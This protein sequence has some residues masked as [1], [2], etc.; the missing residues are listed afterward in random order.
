MDNTSK[1]GKYDWKNKEYLI[2]YVGHQ[3]SP[4]HIIG[5]HAFY[6][7][8]HPVGGGSLYAKS[9]TS[10]LNT[11]Y[12]PLGIPADSTG[13][14]VY[15]RDDD[16]GEFWAT[17]WQP[18]KKEGEAIKYSCRHGFGYCVYQSE[19]EN[20][21]ASHK[22]SM[23]LEDD[24]TL[25]D[26]SV[27][28]IGA[29]TRNLSIYTFVQWEN[30]RNFG[31]V[32]PSTGFV[33]NAIMY[34]SNDDEQVHR[35]FTASF[36]ADSYDCWL[37]SFLGKTGS[38]ASPEAVLQGNCSNSLGQTD[39]HCGVFHKKFTLEEDQEVRLFCLYGDG[40]FQS[41]HTLG[42]KYANQE[43]ADG[44][45]RRLEHY[46]NHL[47]NPENI[48]GSE[49]EEPLFHEMWEQYTREMGNRVLGHD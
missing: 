32:S 18:V 4:R 16:T 47:V 31:A 10:K 45:A 41:A 20:I 1:Y 44:E 29:K 2:D 25:W 37:S 35:F 9:D 12:R 30:D 19:H 5:N 26:I 40:N 23:A 8:F 13:H 46:W 6:G 24:V 17:T 38:L 3:G 42:G 7:I 39:R 11:Q 21:I 33:D 14:L 34:H 36:Q 28:N 43:G 15:L 49:L 27:Q 48:V 22:L